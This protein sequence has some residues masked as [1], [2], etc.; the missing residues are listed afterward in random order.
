ML[1]WDH[2]KNLQ[3]MGFTCEELTEALKRM[4]KK[5]GW[6]KLNKVDCE[7]YAREEFQKL[8]SQMKNL[9]KKN[10]L[11]RELIY[12]RINL[13][14]DVSDGLFEYHVLKTFPNYEIVRA[15]LIEKFEKGE[16]VEGEK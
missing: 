9:A 15:G 7:E 13:V 16:S 8:L 11:L 2:L 6:D 4:T 5:G 12:P 3:V 14:K 10:L 1:N